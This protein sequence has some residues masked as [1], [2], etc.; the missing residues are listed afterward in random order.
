MKLLRPNWQAPSHIK[1]VSTTRLGGVSGFPYESLNLGDHVGDDPHAVAQN[2]ALLLEHIGVSAAQWLQQV[3]GVDCIQAEIDNTV[4]VADACWTDKRDLACIIMTADCLP[5]VFTDGD[6]VAAA[7]AGW[8]GL[9]SGVLEN[10]LAQFPDPQSVDVWLGPA[11]GPAAFEVGAEV[12]QQF[13][14]KSPDS[15]AFFVAGRS[16]D[17]WMADLYGLARSCLLQAGVE[18]ITGG[19]YCTFSD[20]DNFYS[21]R[22]TPQTGRMATLI[23]KT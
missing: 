11:I 23:W 6:K 7:H 21:Y 3:H 5:V 12:K 9:V 18:R 15:A 13:C 14:D 16:P 10:T 4:R 2:R 22:R 19:E 1:V 8:R 17:K 20:A